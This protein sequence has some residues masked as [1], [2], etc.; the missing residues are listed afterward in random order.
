MLKTIIAGSVFA[1]VASA[2][3]HASVV[4]TFSYD[5]DLRAGAVLGA[6]NPDF[7]AGGLFQ[8]TN[9]RSPEDGGSA[10]AAATGYGLANPLDFS[11]GASA[12]GNAVVSVT[13][14]VLVTLTNDS[15][16]ASNASLDSLIYGGGVGVALANFAAADCV[17]GNIAQCGSF[18][19]AP[20]DT[21][22]FATLVFEAT[23]DG[24][25]LFSGDVS[26]LANGTTSSSFDGVALTGFGLA[27]GNSTFFSWQ[28]T[29]LSDVS[30]GSFAVGQSKDLEFNI[31]ILVGTARGADADICSATPS[32]GCSIAQA[33]F[34]DPRGGGGGV[35]TYSSPPASTP[36]PLFNIQFAAIDPNPIP[37]PP[38]LALF[39]LG[40]AAIAGARRRRR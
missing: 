6:V 12:A 11:S 32:L 22:Q 27:S 38:A 15:G 14:R 37:L 7:P 10:F 29:L 34:G 19:G 24:V 33:G 3:A 35:I 39:P 26:V 31:S 25:R 21:G 8:V 1:F 13:N 28:D 16:V 36:F 9:S 23:L 30:L 4:T 17:F 2:A 40:L 18:L 20:G 5:A